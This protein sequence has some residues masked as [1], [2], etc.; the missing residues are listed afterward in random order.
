M[1]A[2]DRAKAIAVAQTVAFLN[3]RKVVLDDLIGVGGEDLK[4]AD[5]RRAEKARHVE[6]CWSLM[7]KLGVKF[8]DIE[9]SEQAPRPTHRNPTSAQRGEGHFCQVV[10]NTGVSPA[11]PGK[12]KPNKINDLGNSVPVASPQPNSEIAS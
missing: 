7:A 2:A 12:V 5:P 1:S 4:S 9:Q 6:K 11:S 8:V 3:K 10:E